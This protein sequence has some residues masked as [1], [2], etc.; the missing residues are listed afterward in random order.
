MY[1]E[2]FD[3]DCGQWFMLIEEEEYYCEYGDS[4]YDDRD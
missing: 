1:E 4:E 2:G 3:E